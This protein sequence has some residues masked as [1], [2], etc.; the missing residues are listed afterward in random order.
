MLTYT[1][2]SVTR[3]GKKRPVYRFQTEDKAYGDFSVVCFRNMLCAMSQSRIT[4]VTWTT[5]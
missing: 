4:R 3:N 2:E 1:V 5:Q